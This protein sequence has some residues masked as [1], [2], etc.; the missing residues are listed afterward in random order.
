MT[1]AGHSTLPQWRDTVKP[2]LGAALAGVLLC[3]AGAYFMPAQLLRSYLVAFLFWL[4]LG[5][6]S[7]VLLMIQHVT[8]GR[9]GLVLRP[10]LEAGSKTLLVSA[11]LFV[12]IALGV[13]L[14]YPWAD[15]EALMHGQSHHQAKLIS[16]MRGKE[17]YLNVPFFLG[18]AV[19]YLAVWVGLSLVLTRLTDLYN[20]RHDPLTRRRMRTISGPGLA[21]YGLTVTFAAVDWIMSLEPEWFSSIFGVVLAVSQLLPALA[22][23]IVVL[24]WLAQRPAVAEAMREET[25]GDLGNLLLAFTMLWAYIGFSQYFLIWSANLPEENVWYLHRTAGAWEW[26]AWALIVVQFVLPFALLLSADVKR[27]PRRLRWVAG[28]VLVMSYVHYYWQVMPAPEALGHGAPGRPFYPETLWL[29][30]G[31]FLVVGGPWLA[32]FVWCLQARPLLPEKELEVLA[33]VHHA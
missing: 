28:I 31:A 24:I 27:E 20:Q 29:D 22:F 32:Y 16:L 23:A 9:W 25:W 2:A 12:P 17:P 10:T 7:L 6:G 11:V 5:L 8:G 18:R 1:V 4:G 13:D 21:L 33:E 19:F 14:L 26:I 30:V 3:A 15:W